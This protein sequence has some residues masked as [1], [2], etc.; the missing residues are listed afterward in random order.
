MSPTQERVE[1]MRELARENGRRIRA[2]QLEDC[3]DG[4]HD[5]C[6]EVRNGVLLPEMLYVCDCTCHD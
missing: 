6:P 2:W 1:F 3:Q 5:E 4:K